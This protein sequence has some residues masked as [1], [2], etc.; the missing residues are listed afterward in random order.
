VSLLCSPPQSFANVVSSYWLRWRYWRHLGSLG[1]IRWSLGEVSRQPV[2]FFRLLIPSVPKVRGPPESAVI[3][4]V[5]WLAWGKNWWK[6]HGY[7]LHEG[8]VIDETSMLITTS[9]LTFVPYPNI[10]VR[11]FGARCIYPSIFRYRNGVPRMI[12]GGL[13]ISVR[14]CWNLR[15]IL[16]YFYRYHITVRYELKSKLSDPIRTGVPRRLQTP[17]LHTSI[18]Y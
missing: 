10:S 6:R 11:S 7:G 15:D 14:R 2:S 4:N 3:E 9:W 16:R 13:L 18:M 5:K 12:F 17:P 1:G 8:F